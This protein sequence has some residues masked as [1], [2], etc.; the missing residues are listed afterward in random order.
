MEQP[1]LSTILVTLVMITLYNTFLALMESVTLSTTQQPLVELSPHY[2][3]LCPKVLVSNLNSKTTLHAD[4]AGSVLY[5]GSGHHC[6]LTGLP[7]SYSSE[8]VFD[9]LVHN[10]DT[11]FNPTANIPL[12]ICV[13]KNNLPDCSERK[14]KIGAHSG[15]MFQISVVAVGQ[16]DGTV[17]STVTST[18]T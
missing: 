6:K 2:T 9:R 13:C 4:I 8:E 1:T 10:N 15:E 14:V 5:G 12:Y 18:V 3:M 7:N 11:A 17:P 16:R